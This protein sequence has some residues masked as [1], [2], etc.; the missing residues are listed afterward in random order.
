[1]N[2]TKALIERY[3]D[4]FNR[5]DM[6][7]FMA[8]LHDNIVHFANQSERVDGKPKF[9]HF[10]EHMNFCYRERITDLIVFSSDDGKRAAA[11]Y[12][13]NGMYLNTDQGLP[14]ARS[15]TYRVTGGAFF[16]IKDGLIIRVNN[17]Y[18]LQEW[19]RQ[20]T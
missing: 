16:A 9:G 18:N 17:Y 7:T 10:M 12:T 15:Q 6:T 14:P 19:L 4:S 1:M 3:Y 5:S 8:T 13:V 20:V 11:E 2:D